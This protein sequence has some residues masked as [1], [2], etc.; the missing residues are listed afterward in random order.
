MN[1]KIVMLGQLIGS[2][3]SSEKK[4]TL[5]D[6]YNS[7]DLVTYPSDIEGFGNAFLEAIYYKKP[8][9]VNRYAVYVM[10]IEPRGFDVISFDDMVTSDVVERI[11]K[12]LTDSGY[13]E[14]M[15]NHNFRVAKEFF[16]YEVLEKKLLSVIETF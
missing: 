8:I 12:V 4:F 2:N 9:V 16:S 14:A 1:V 7:A 15:V 11:E 13:Q 10:D 6:V 3:Q 5:A